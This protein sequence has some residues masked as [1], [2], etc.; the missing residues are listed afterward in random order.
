MQPVLLDAAPGI[1]IDS[2]IIASVL[3]VLVASLLAWNGWITVNVIKMMVAAEGDR[4]R[5]K[6]ILDALYKDIPQI[7][8]RT[9]PR[10]YTDREKML[11]SRFQRDA[12]TLNDDELEEMRRAADEKRKDP[13]E[14]SGEQLTAAWLQA[15]ARMEQASRQEKPGIGKFFRGLLWNFRP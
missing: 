2:Q 10:P 15:A 8:L 12:A 1:A 11:I 5:I 3:S 4:A 6:P 14:P 7:A 13:G 9:N